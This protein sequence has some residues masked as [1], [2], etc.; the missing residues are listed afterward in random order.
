M[1][2]EIEVD[3][4]CSKLFLHMAIHYNIEYR[5]DLLLSTKYIYFLKL[6]KNNK[7]VQYLL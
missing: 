3:L 2:K 6:F 7:L 1:N 4:P 5:N